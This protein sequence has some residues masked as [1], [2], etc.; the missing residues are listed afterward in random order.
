MYAHAYIL[1]SSCSIKHV[2]LKLQTKFFLQFFFLFKFQ[3]YKN[4]WKFSSQFLNNIIGYFQVYKTC[5]E[6]ANHHHHHIALVARI[7]LTLSRH[8]SLWFIAL[9]RSSGQH[10][11]SSH[12]C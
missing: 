8:S 7:S 5:C 6:T 10:P 3:L 2:F 11:V 4:C 12:S 9:G 1:K